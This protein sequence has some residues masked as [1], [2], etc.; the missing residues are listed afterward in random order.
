MKKKKAIIPESV[1]QHIKDELKK[2][3]DFR[4]AYSDEVTRL[5]LAYKITQLRKARNLSQAQLAKRVGTT[6]QTISRLEDS[7]NTRITIATLS[8]LSVA[9]QA[10]LSIEL[11]PKKG[12][13]A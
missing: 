1:S 10:H 4:K 12:K 3:S 13:A 11:L 7:K 9:L 8:K 2:S 6:Q 5:Q